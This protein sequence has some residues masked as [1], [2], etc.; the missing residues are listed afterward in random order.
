M[1]VD[2]HDFQRPHCKQ[3]GILIRYIGDFLG[4]HSEAEVA[5]PWKTLSVNAAFDEH[6]P[7]GFVNAKVFGVW[8]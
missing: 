6:V 2:V 4:P 1:V 5:S 8:S 7:R 3:F